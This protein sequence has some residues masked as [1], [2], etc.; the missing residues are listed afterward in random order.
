MTLINE[1]G[2]KCRKCIYRNRGR[3]GGYG[4]DHSFI[5]G[6]SRLKRGL[7]EGIARLDEAGNVDFPIEA[8]PYWQDKEVFRPGKTMHEEEKQIK[9]RKM[10]KGGT[11]TDD[12]RLEM[13]QA[14]FSDKEIAQRIG[15][16]AVAV[17]QWRIKNGLLKS[18]NLA[19]L[20]EDQEE[21]RMALYRKGYNDCQIARALGMSANG[22]FN[23]R[24]R[25]GLPSNRGVTQ[26]R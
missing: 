2:R 24:K 4:C 26:K 19:A 3:I 10:R 6:M 1:G 20:P 16:S 15:R 18:G 7:D 22:V 5:V 9:K 21:R 8:C 12:L 17:Q 14:G 13:V 11:D 23:W 25:R